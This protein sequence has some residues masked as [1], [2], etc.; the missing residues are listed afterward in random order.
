[1]NHIS[2][3]AP[4]LE[5]RVFRDGDGCV[6]FVF[7][8]EKYF[9]FDDSKAFHRKLTVE[10]RDDNAFILCLEGSVD[11][12]NIFAADACIDHGI[13]V[14]ANEVG[15][16]GML[17]EMAIQVELLLDAVVRGRRKTGWHLAEKERAF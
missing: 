3:H 9:T 10:Y 7:G 2:D 12:E 17:D 4:N 16:G 1:M 14:D 6:V 5:A 15:G 13:A 11:N 8:H